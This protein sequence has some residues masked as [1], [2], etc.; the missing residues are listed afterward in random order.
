MKYEGREIEGY[1][2]A[3]TSEKVYSVQWWGNGVEEMAFVLLKPQP[4]LAWLSYIYTKAIKKGPLICHS[5]GC[6][7]K[8]IDTEQTS[9]FQHSL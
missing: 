8:Q 3:S 7:W 5:V 2:S 6:F 1:E 4:H 9:A